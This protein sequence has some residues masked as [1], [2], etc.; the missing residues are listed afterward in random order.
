MENVL[1]VQWTHDKVTGIEDVLPV[2]WTHDKVTVI[3]DVLPVQWTHDKVTGIEDVLPVQWTHLMNNKDVGRDMCGT[4]FKTNDE[5]HDVAMFSLAIVLRGGAVV[6]HLCSLNKGSMGASSCMFS[7][8]FQHTS[9]SR[10]T[11]SSEGRLSLIAIDDCTASFLSDLHSKLFCFVIVTTNVIT[12]VILSH[13]ASPCGHSEIPNC[14]ECPGAMTV[15][16]TMDTI[17]VRQV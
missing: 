16:V 3:E 5:G 13:V 9:S 17:N 4:I 6:C 14:S 12:L 8:G 1:P 11:N 10:G 15:S 2:Q 7:I